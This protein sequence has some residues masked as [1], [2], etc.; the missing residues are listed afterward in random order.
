VLL[1]F[2]ELIVKTSVKLASLV[3]AAKRIAYAGMA[4][5]VMQ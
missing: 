5:H 4:V 3:L 2:M 1:V